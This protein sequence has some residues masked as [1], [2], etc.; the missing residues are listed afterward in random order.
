MYIISVICNKIEIMI[1]RF[2]YLL[3]SSS[4]QDVWVYL[5]SKTSVDEKTIAIA[6]ETKSRA[7]AVKKALKGDLK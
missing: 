3:W 4:L 5:W 7:K 6:K 1:K 2:F